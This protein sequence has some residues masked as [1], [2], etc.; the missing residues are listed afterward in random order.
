M[1]QKPTVAAFF[2]N[3]RKIA[4]QLHKSLQLEGCEKDS[5]L[6]QT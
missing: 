5:T 4:V 3:P 1:K 6:L 2:L